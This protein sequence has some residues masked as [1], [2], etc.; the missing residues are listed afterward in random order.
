MT[1]IGST[2]PHIALNPQESFPLASTRK[3]L[4]LGA[5]AVKVADGSF[6]PT[7]PVSVED[8]ERWYWEGTDGGV[9]ELAKKE[10]VQQGKISGSVVLTLDDVVHAMIR[11]SDN[12]AADYVL[13][14]VG[15]RDA[16]AEF[17]KSVGMQFQQPLMPVFGEFIAWSSEDVDEWSKLQPDARAR[18]AEELAEKTPPSALEDLKLPPT[19]AQFEFAKTSPAGVPEEWARLMSTLHTGSLPVE[20]IDVTRRH[21]EWPLQV[22]PSN[23]QKFESFGDKGGSLPGVLTEA[24]YVEPKGGKAWSVALF[25]RDVPESDW[26]PL[27]QS[28]VHQRFILGLIE[29]EKLREE[30]NQALSG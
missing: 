14:R 3:V 27:V 4:I 8:V 28:F 21:L 17:A 5:Y 15:G 13:N 22:F 9:H 25:I 10:W 26:R 1:E 24:M 30:A 23:R 2:E 12:A 29:D 6:D 11:W 18:R 7:Q 16:A 19:S 20:A